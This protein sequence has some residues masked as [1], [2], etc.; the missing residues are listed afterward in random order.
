MRHQTKYFII[1]TGAFILPVLFSDLANHAEVAR[2][3]TGNTSNIVGAGFCELQYSDA[4]VIDWQAMS[5]R[6]VCYGES[7]SL[8]IKSR[9]EKDAKIINK[10]LG[11]VDDD[12]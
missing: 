6:Y 2:A 5:P 1:D 7:T 4:S 12:Y 9:G 3:L 10:Y 11:V 8:G